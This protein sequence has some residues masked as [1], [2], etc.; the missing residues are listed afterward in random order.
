MNAVGYARVS[1]ELQA[2]EGVSLEAQKAA[3]VHWTETNGAAL[4]EVFTDAGISGTGMR[5]RPGLQE[6]LQL[7]CEKKA[8]LV[9]Y[10]LSRISRSTKDTLQISEKLDKAGADLVSLS[11]KIDTTS[12]S[13]KMIFRLLAVL[14]EFE[15]DVV[16]ERTSAALQ[17]KKANGLVYSPIPYGLAREGRRLIPN[18][19]EERVLQQMRAWRVEGRSYQWIAA[20]LNASQIHSKNGGRWYAS[21]V[22]SVLLTAR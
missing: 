2:R 19:H 9:A 15:R 18:E 4:L 7:V 20:N 11:E 3:I 8:V 6:A 10:S 1:T 22:R 17:H 21:T 5:Q 13:G 12:A 16:A 14:A